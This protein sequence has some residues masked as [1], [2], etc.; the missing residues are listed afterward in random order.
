LSE[1]I[2]VHS[3]LDTIGGGERVCLEVARAIYEN[4]GS[5]PSLLLIKK[6]SKSI[7][8]KTVT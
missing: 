7:K 5:K 2:I 3:D 6:A 4:F 1:W 8:S